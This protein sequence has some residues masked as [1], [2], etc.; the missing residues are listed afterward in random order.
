M[1][2]LELTGSHTFLKCTDVSQEQ[3]LTSDLLASGITRLRNL[4]LCGNPLA[5]L[6]T[7]CGQSLIVSLRFRGRA[8]SAS[9]SNTLSRGMYGFSRLLTGEWLILLAARQSIV[10]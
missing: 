2:K 1:T 9:L 10:K 3:M 4:I 8:A 5:Q 7:T 6:S